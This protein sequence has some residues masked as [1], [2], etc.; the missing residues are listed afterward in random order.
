MNHKKSVLLGLLIWGMTFTCAMLLFP[1]RQNDRIFFEALIPVVLT[2]STLVASYF[3]FA[4]SKN[5]Y[6]VQ[7]YCLGLIWL[8]VNLFMD[9]F[10]FS[11]GPMKMSLANYIKDIGVTYLIILI[12]PSGIGYMLEKKAK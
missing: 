2:L 4:D 12:I 8:G 3:Y 7:G 10:A 9:L 6:F 1:L 11:W 5:R